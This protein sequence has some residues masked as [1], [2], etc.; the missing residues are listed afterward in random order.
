[1]ESNGRSNGQIAE[2]ARHEP[3][4]CYNACLKSVVFGGFDGLLSSI[5]VVSGAVGMHLSWQALVG[6]TCAVVVASSLSTGMSEFLSS[7]AHRHFIQAEKRRELWEFK[8]FKDEEMQEM[9]SRFE[10][11]GMSRND[12]ST[13]VQTLAQYESV[14]VNMMV[15]DD[16][17]LQ[18]AEEDDALLL[19]DAFVMLAS[20][21]LFGALPVL[22]YGIGSLA[23]GAMEEPGAGSSIGDAANPRDPDPDLSASMGLFWFSIVVSQIVLLGLGSA[24]STFSSS[25]WLVAFLETLLLG[26]SCAAVAYVVGSQIAGL[27]I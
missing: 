25:N 14:F 11:R 6:L 24:K 20:F 10:G 19:T 23:V 16:L 9:I 21:A 12:A 5:I 4:T 15:A 8:H 26:S 7:R 17:G 3:Q 27:V 2:S 13:V 1:M 22:V 18:L